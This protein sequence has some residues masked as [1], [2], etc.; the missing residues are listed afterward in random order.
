MNRIPLYLVALIVA[1]AN[2]PLDIFQINAW[3]HGTV[4]VEP[5]RRKL[6]AAIGARITAL[7]TVLRSW[8]RASG[9]LPAAVAVAVCLAVLVATPH[10]TDGVL[11]AH[12]AFGLKGL[13]AARRRPEGRNR[14]GEE[15]QGGDRRDGHAREPRDDRGGKGQVPRLHPAD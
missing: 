8:F 4:K 6:P 11:F 12:V 5:W 2:T 1:I 13:P 7:S 14:E 15:G 10:V 3:N 9:G